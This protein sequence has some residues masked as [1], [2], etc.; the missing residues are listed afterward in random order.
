MTIQQKWYH[1]ALSWKLLNCITKLDIFLEMKKYTCV[2]V[3]SCSTFF[4]W[5][6]I[7]CTLSPYWSTSSWH[8]KICFC[9]CSSWKNKQLF[10]SLFTFHNKINIQ[11]TNT[12]DFKDFTLK[13]KKRFSVNIHILLFWSHQKKNEAFLVYKTSDSGW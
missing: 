6:D 2:W 1:D 12:K 3:L 9:F 10:M 11:S 13:K 7:E 8:F 5:P 4:R